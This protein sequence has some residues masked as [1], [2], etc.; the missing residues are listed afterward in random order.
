[1]QEQM[2]TANTK[3]EDLALTPTIAATHPRR[4]HPAATLM[5][6]PALDSEDQLPLNPG[7]ASVRQP[8]T[9]AALSRA[10]RDRLPRGVLRHFCRFG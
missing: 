4:I 3:L 2:Y 9:D 7:L 1:M 10:L 8:A 5:M 6:L